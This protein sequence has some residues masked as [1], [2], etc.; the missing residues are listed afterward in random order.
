VTVEPGDT[1]PG[2]VSAIT[3]AGISWG[4]AATAGATFSFRLRATNAFGYSTSSAISGTVAAA[5]ASTGFF[6]G[7][8]SVQHTA[9]GYVGD[10]DN[11]PTYS[12]KQSRMIAHPDGRHFYFGGDTAN[13]SGEQRIWSLRPGPWNTSTPSTGWR[14]EH[15]EWPLDGNN[16]PIRTDCQ[17]TVWDSKR[18][19][20]WLMAGYSTGNTTGKPAGAIGFKDKVAKFDPAKP[21]GTQWTPTA[22][23]M[24]AQG[25][26]TIGGE[27]VGSAVYD[28]VLDL[29]FHGG[30]ATGWGKLHAF[31]PAAEAFAFVATL[32]QSNLEILSDGWLLGVVAFD[33]VNRWLWVM[34]SVMK[35]I[36]NV[37]TRNLYRVTLPTSRAGLPTGGGSVDWTSLAV[38]V[39]NNPSN[40]LDLAGG[41]CAILDGDARKWY[42]WIRGPLGAAPGAMGG[43][44]PQGNNFQSGTCGHPIAGNGSFGS[45]NTGALVDLMTGAVEYAQVQHMQYADG[46]GWI[47][48]T[49]TYYSEK[50]GRLIYMVADESGTGVAGQDGILAKHYELR[51]KALPS[52]APSTLYQWSQVIGAPASS[53]PGSVRTEWEGPA[54]PSTGTK[55]LLNA[56]Q[57]PFIWSR[58]AF[59]QKDATLLFHSGGGDNGNAN[60]ILALTCNSETPSWSVALPPTPAALCAPNWS[61]GIGGGLDPQNPRGYNVYFNDPA[62]DSINA[63]GQKTPVAVHAYTSCHFVESHDAW[64]RFGNC[65]TWPTDGYSTTGTRDVHA[66]KWSELSKPAASRLWSLN[67]SPAM[68][69]TPAIP[70]DGMVLHPWRG[71]VIFG[72]YGDFRLWRA[73]S[74]DYQSGYLAGGGLGTTVAGFQWIDPLNDVAV[75]VGTPGSVAPF[76]LDLAA[77]DLTSVSIKKNGNAV[78]SWGGPDGASFLGSSGEYTW[79]DDNQCIWCVKARRSGITPLDSDF[80]L[81][82]IVL[83]DKAACT[84]SVTKV[85]TSGTKPTWTGQGDADSLAVKWSRELGCLLVTQ[86]YNKPISFIR[87]SARA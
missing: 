38:E 72:T 19:I 14:L 9:F 36:V 79:D 8:Q 50:H 40:G 42:G 48:P 60:G 18:R 23:T 1:L 69:S 15:P 80:D 70:P 86:G 68:P 66:F 17:A 41:S 34:R 43:G 32:K 61:A 85:T 46:Q 11:G 47:I 31:D 49:Q 22:V 13:N 6:A 64:I 29:V 83:T 58:G 25:L 26:G 44:L 78:T 12:G 4:T 59:R 27:R 81:F 57:G 10:N 21:Q 76:L 54:E 55:A 45:V 16:Y 73:A 77:P 33:P 30:D 65:Q 71:D 39:W 51:R 52:W 24:A 3:I 62:T 20:F 7:W 5:P 56:S 67:Y 84:F 63:N 74:N 28:P 37:N 2:W 75:Y 87:T 53:I 82:K 35:N